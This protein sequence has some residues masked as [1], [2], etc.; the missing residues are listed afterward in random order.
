[1]TAVPKGYTGHARDLVREQLAR[2]SQLVSRS[3][4]EITPN[5]KV[6]PRTDG[7]FVIF[8]KR[9]ELGK[10]AGVFESD[11]RAIA[12]ARRIYAAELA[13]KKGP[14]KQ[15]AADEEL[16]AGMKRAMANG[17]ATHEPAY[18]EEPSR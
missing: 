17:F 7:R 15:S 13:T 5:V 18:D 1:M 2:G 12:E 3:G 14:A 10:D 4:V 11:E 6:Y 9:L 8:D 16:F